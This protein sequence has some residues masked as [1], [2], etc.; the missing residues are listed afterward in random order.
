MTP[1]L[2]VCFF[3]S[4]SHRLALHLSLT[5]SFTF[6]FH[7]FSCFLSLSLSSTLNWLWRTCSCDWLTD[8]WLELPFCD[9]CLRT[10]V[11]Q[12]MILLLTR[13]TAQ[14]EPRTR[15][16]KCVACPSCLTSKYVQREK[17]G[18][19]SLTPVFRCI[20]HLITTNYVL[21]ALVVAAGPAV[22]L[23]GLF[24]LA[25]RTVNAPELL[26]SIS[27]NANKIRGI[28]FWVDI[29]RDRWK[30]MCVCG[31][32]CK[33]VRYM[34]LGNQMGGWKP[35]LSNKCICQGNTCPDSAHHLAL[36]LSLSLYLP[37]KWLSENRLCPI[38]F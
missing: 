4:V 37:K 14:F 8:E 6:S 24:Y 10:A 19:A 28:Y 29:L 20:T 15:G 35:L 27:S 7:F 34:D 1:I 26:R 30:F 16:P 31:M 33:S 12:S 3:S 32:L 22:T 36:S 18:M 2:F 23:F 17:S 9:V 5:L 38:W 13:K 25:F 21:F 11:D